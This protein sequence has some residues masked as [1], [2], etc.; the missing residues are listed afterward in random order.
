M[1]NFSHM[2]H[3]RVEKMNNDFKKKVRTQI[4]K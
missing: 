2:K 3:E 4:F 1:L